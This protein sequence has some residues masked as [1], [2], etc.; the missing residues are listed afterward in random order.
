MTHTTHTST[1]FLFQVASEKL[2]YIFIYKKLIA[3]VVF[4]YDF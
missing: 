3:F 1:T 4:F 2:V